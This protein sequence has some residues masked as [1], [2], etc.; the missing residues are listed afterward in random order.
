MLSNV[1]WGQQHKYYLNLKNIRI[2][3]KTSDRTC[4]NMVKIVVHYKNNS[5]EVVFERNHPPTSINNIDNILLKDDVLSIETYHTVIDAV[6]ELFSTCCN[7]AHTSKYEKSQRNS[8][9][10]CNISNSTISGSSSDGQA[11]G[12]FSFNYELIPIH[13]LYP[14]VI[15]I[16][17]GI[18]SYNTYLPSDDKI[19]LLAKEGFDS[20][21]YHYQYSLDNTN[22]E[23]IDSSLHNL[24][25]LS[26]S[27]KDLFGE[28]YKQHLGKKIYFRV[29]SCLE[30][31]Q[32]R[33]VSNSIFLTLT[34]SAPHISSSQ[35]FPTKCFD[36]E[37]GSVLINFNRKLLPNES[38]EYVLTNKDTGTTFR[39]GNISTDLQN[40][41][42]ITLN[43]IP[44]GRYELK[45]LGNYL[46][47]ATYTDG[48]AHSFN[49]EVT[50]PTAVTFDA[51]HKNVYCH[52]GSD[53]E[54]SIT[55]SGGQGSFQYFI[56]KNG[57]PF[58]DWTNFNNGNSATIK[59]LDAGTYAVKVRDTNFCIAKNPTNS[60]LEKEITLNI[61]Q[62]E[63]PIA[64]SEIETFTPTGY[65]LSN[66]YI[67]VRVTGGTPN[68]DGSYFYEWRKNT[69]DGEIITSNI[70]TDNTNQP[71]TIKLG[72]IPAGT[73]YLTVKDKNY[74]VATSNLN[75]C[76]IISKV[77]NVSQP[78]PLIVNIK[79]QEVISCNINNDYRSKNDHNQNNIPDEAE[80]GVLFADV[81]G[82][83]KDYFYQWQ[84][85]NGGVFQNISNA[86]ENKLA[87]LSEGTY[88]VIIKDKN[89]NTTE[90]VYTL[91]YPEELKLNITANTI[92]CYNSN[93]GILSA[94]VTGGTGNYSYQW[95]NGETTP[96]IKNLPADKYTLLITDGKGCNVYGKTEI[97]QSSEIIVTDISVKNPTCYGANNGEIK[98]SISGGKLPYSIKWSN[99]ATTEHLSNIGAGTYTLIVTDA[100]GCSISKKYTLS[101]PD[102]LTIDLGQDITLCSGDSQS[103]DVTIDDP[104]ATYQWLDQNGNTIS[105]SAKISISNAGT[106]TVII[107]NANGCQATD[108]VVI[109]NSLDVLS[110]HFLVSTHSYTDSSVILVNT[111]EPKPQSVE[112]IVPNDNTI[113][114]VNKN[115]D[116]LELQ[117]STPGSYTIGLKGN[118]GEC[119]KIFYKNIIV[120]NN[121]SGID[122]KPNKAS[123]IQDFNIL[124]NPNKGIFEVLVN[125]YQEKSIKIRILDM[126]SR[127]ISVEIAK[128]ANKKFVIPYNIS[129][130]AG[131]YIVILEAGDEVLVKRMIVHQ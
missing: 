17:N 108:S 83:V 104:L 81:K 67:S 70:I 28:N 64:L 11:R 59:N 52:A 30:N 78:E 8:P 106:Y 29:V 54:I 12:S 6:D 58:A 118:Q 61:T 131:N 113:Q 103:Y 107:T 124:P 39:N 62:P 80:D 85:S 117:F 51:T 36:S 40:S 7:C 32:Y 115:N 18:P 33:S 53:G 116:Y 77:F 119:S 57:Q 97:K 129:I 16:Q 26:I 74:S 96:T 27:A 125:L 127:P 38:L 112:W 23:D 35:V 84:I 44:A 68:S 22:W 130:P 5:S 79:V 86:T 55:A 4:T 71:F 110:P 47:N 82:G 37:D 48:A 101:Q 9:S 122:T 92:S 25:K 128:S 72:N 121:D 114:V 60:N 19:N 73:Y 75:H 90:A 126:L 31:G 65:G 14:E 105:T 66:G 56:T 21:L 42:S 98:V 91:S 95:S 10:Y 69:P 41:T 46:G 123:N 102:A 43:D 76:G 2:T 111:S 88:K 3:E 120:E 109:K 89:N 24:H 34:E 99:N 50:K 45:F 49:F 93:S 13:T 15:S 87:N 20:N 63:S 1:V 94:F 100:N